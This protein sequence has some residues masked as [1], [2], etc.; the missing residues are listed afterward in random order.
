MPVCT[1]PA[2]WRGWLGSNQRIRESKS[3]ALPL[4]YSPIR[5]VG[6]VWI[7]TTYPG[8][9]AATPSPFFRFPAYSYNDHQ[10]QLVLHRTLRNRIPTGNRPDTFGSRSPFASDIGTDS[11]FRLCGV[12]CSVVSQCYRFES[13][14]LSRKGAT[15]TYALPAELL[16]PLRGGA[17]RRSRPPAVSYDRCG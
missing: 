14:R 17:E 7:C 2:W 9:A 3:R 5:R 15:L 1:C 10:E 12:A 13:V 6:E 4:G 8:L 11:V 16:A